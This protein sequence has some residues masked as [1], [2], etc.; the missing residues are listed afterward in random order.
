MNYLDD[1]TD[2][3]L[4]NVIDEGIDFE[5]DLNTFDNDDDLLTFDESEI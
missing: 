1:L 3:E 5:M 2:Y 4:F